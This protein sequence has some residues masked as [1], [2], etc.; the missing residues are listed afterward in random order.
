MSMS[1]QTYN[2]MSLLS[3]PALFHNIVCFILMYTFG[4]NKLID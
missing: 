3:C 4:A 2:N 1:E